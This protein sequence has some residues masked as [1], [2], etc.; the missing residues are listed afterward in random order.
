MPLYVQRWSLHATSRS[1][2]CSCR[3]STRTPQRIHMELP[4]PI[5]KSVRP[6]VHFIH[7]WFEQDIRPPARPARPGP[8]RP[9]PASVQALKCKSAKCKN[10]E[11][12]KMHNSRAGPGNVWNLGGFP[13]AGRRHAPAFPA[14]GPCMFRFFILRFCTFSLLCFA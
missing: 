8:A 12:A 5:G 2:C 11:R 14:G 4:K 10:A 7:L 9:G 3:S 13:G 1:F 6:P